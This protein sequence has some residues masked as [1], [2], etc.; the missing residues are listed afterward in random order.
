MNKYLLTL[1]GLLVLFSTTTQAQSKKKKKKLQEVNL[2]IT[3]AQ[4]YLGTPYQYGGTSSRGIDC[5]SLIQ[6]SYSQAG[7][8]VPRTSK[9]QSKYGKKVSLNRVKPGDVVFF[10]FKKK[11]DKWL[12]SGLI[13]STD[14]D[15]VYFI[16]ASSSKGVVQSDLYADYYKSRIRTIRRVIK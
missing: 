14:S 5:S 12:H 11:G 3:T 6:N 15:K 4:S 2:V 10:K 9:D 16:H 13:T 8:T 7:Y 1:L